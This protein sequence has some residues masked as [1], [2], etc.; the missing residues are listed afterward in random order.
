MVTNT[1]TLQLPETTYALLI[2]R[3]KRIG[4]VPEQIVLQWIINA[5]QAE[6]EAEDPLLQLA[7]IFA[8]E[9]SDISERH[10]EYIGHE[11]QH[12]HG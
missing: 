5:V 9:T 4:Q 12:A 1:L 8:G 10:D 11:A 7:G 2:R 6:S 3:A